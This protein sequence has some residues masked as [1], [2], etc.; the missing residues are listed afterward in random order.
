MEFP[1]PYRGQEAGKFFCFPENLLTFSGKRCIIH[2]NPLG[3]IRYEE[4]V[5][6]HAFITRSLI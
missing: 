5:P 4:E 3:I 2:T 1:I 6:C